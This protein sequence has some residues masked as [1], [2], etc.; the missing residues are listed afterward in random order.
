MTGF[1]TEDVY[2]WEGV[3]DVVPPQ[4]AQIGMIMDI[5]GEECERVR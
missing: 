1:R 2:L 3:R 4:Q 5:K